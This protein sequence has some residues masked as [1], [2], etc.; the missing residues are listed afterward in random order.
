MSSKR[1]HSRKVNEPQ[2][3]HHAVQDV[4]SGDE[5]EGDE[6]DV[7][8]GVARSLIPASNGSK[9]SKSDDETDGGSFTYH[10][11]AIYR[12]YSRTV[13]S[14]GNNARWVKEPNISTFPMKLHEI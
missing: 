5:E 4:S 12:D 14:P 3:Y 1:I 8:T 2:H 9:N 6:Y 7:D 10:D 13:T 11:S